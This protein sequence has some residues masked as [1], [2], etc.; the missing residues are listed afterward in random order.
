MTFD[1]AVVP[2]FAALIAFGSLLVSIG[3]ARRTGRWRD[4]DDAKELVDRVGQVENRLVKVEASLDGLATKADL[5]GLRSDVRALVRE[6]K[7]TEAGVNR[8]EQWLIEG[9]H[10]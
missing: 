10:R 8:S 1:P 9:K 5:E 6:T 3:V 2:L 7:A 4:D